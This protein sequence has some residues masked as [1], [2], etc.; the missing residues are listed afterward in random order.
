MENY[1][2]TIEEPGSSIGDYLQVLSRRKGLLLGALFAIL[3]LALAVAF[4][5]PPT[6]RSTATIL[7][8]RQEIPEDFVRSTVTTF[9]DQ[10]LA[11]IRQQ[12]MTTANL[13]QVINK[14]DLYPKERERE[15]IE[16]VVKDMAD[17]IDMETVSAEVLDPRTGRASEVTIAFN[18]SYEHEE[19]ATAQR[20]AN[21]LTS[22]YLNENLKNRNQL[23]VQT[24]RFLEEEAKKLQSRVADV[25]GRLAAFKEKHAENL[26]EFANLN[27]QQA[28]KMEA[29]LDDV[30]RQ[31]QTL[32]ERQIYLSTE[33]AQLEPTIVDVNT[34]SARA[35]EQ[36]AMHL[37]ELRNE[38]VRLSTRYSPTHPDV[39]RIKREITTLEA[40]VGAVG[41]D[42]LRERLLVLENLKAV[43]RTKY[44]PTHPEV[45]GIER[46]IRAV[47][48]MIADAPSAPA[49]VPG[50]SGVRENP[51]YVQVRAQLKVARLELAATRNKRSEL[52]AKISNLERK[53]AFSPQVER[54]Y[55]ALT[56]EHE[57]AVLKYQEIKAK[58]I[59]ASIAQSLEND[60]KGERFTLIQPPLLPERPVS[61]NRLAIVFLGIVLSVGGGTGSV[62]LA[63][64]LDTSIRGRRGMNRLFTEPPLAMIPHVP[65]PGERRRRITVR[66]LILGVI[67]ALV[68]VALYWVHTQYTPLDV[69]WYQALRKLGISY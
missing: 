53:M 33:L 15:P 38:Y 37:R 34:P 58:E 69:L 67:L 40:E 20:V 47:K 17:A 25:E 56:R 54:E 68:G 8:E 61:P 10:R 39:K 43:A 9:A 46:S 28:A 11:A 18:V 3:I 49:P 48:A 66:L 30:V 27:L 65:S 6:Y 62:A 7:I 59:E 60:Q 45:R 50:V 42:D 31:I 1:V 12:V 35:D 32:E 26:P 36:G 52:E 4:L 55:L 41:S 24:S 44:S 13:I 23:T 64:M 19:P 14:Y 21:E 57:N 29:S 2:Q 16:Q 63:E 5:V 51:A 22:L